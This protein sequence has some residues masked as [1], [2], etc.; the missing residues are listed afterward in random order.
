MFTL[1][2]QIPYTESFLCSFTRF[3]ARRVSPKDIHN[4]DGTNF[5]GSNAILKEEFEK[6]RCEESQKKICKRL[7]QEKTTRHFNPPI[8]SH[9]GGVWD[10]MI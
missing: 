3:T 4:D 10:N 6:L 7:L 5:V 2:F 1:K 9:T 8:A